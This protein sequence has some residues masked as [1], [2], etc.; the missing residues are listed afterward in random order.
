MACTVYCTYFKLIIKKYVL[1]CTALYIFNMDDAMDIFK[2][3]NIPRNQIKDIVMT[4]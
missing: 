1:Y 4:N 3:M 2:I